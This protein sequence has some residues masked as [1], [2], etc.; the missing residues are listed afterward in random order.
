MSKHSH[1]DGFSHF[2]GKMITLAAIVIVGFVLITMIFSPSEKKETDET[3][4]TEV[5]EQMIVPESC[6]VSGSVHITK[7]NIYAN[8]KGLPDDFDYDL[9]INCSGDDVAVEGAIYATIDGQQCEMQLTTLSGIL[10]INGDETDIDSADI[11][12]LGAL[13][14]GVTYGQNKTTSVDGKSIKTSSIQSTETGYSFNVSLSV[15][16]IQIKANCTAKY[17]RL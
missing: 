4:V 8:A 9:T 11:Y 13:L 1:Y 17:Q 5:T 7:G 3:V 15:M 16:F 2:A 10:Y 6:Y 12:S 14:T